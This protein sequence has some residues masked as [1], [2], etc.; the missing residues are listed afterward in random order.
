MLRQVEGAPLR[1]DNSVQFS[2]PP[3]SV[4]DGRVLSYRDWL[5]KGLTRVT[6]TESGPIR[7]RR[8]GDRIAYNRERN[9]DGTE[10]LEQE[11]VFVR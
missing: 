11:Q 9:S 1:R 4:R 3:T 5:H 7:P 8:P 2:V 6:S 10:T